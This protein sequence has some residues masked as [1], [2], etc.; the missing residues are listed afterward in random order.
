MSYIN[1]FL[2]GDTGNSFVNDG[3]VDLNVNSV[4]VAGML[5]NM[6]VMTDSSNNLISSAL[7]S[8][9][10]GQLT[11]EGPTL[12][13]KSDG[14][15]IYLRAD[16]V[17]GVGEQPVTIVASDLTLNGASVVFQESRSASIRFSTGFDFFNVN[18]NVQR[19]GKMVNLFVPLIS[20][21]PSLSA[22]A[23]TF[24]YPLIG[25]M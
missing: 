24:D 9:P 25:L 6:P 2:N 8:V 1:R 17:D 10:S 5:P 22:G 15:P 7:I 11:L 16:V 4:R 23:M 3:S 14:N 18:V 20:F 12:Y 13:L 19:V 21:T